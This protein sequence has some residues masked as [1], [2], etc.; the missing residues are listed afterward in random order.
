M[1]YG[2]IKEVL[3]KKKVR[4]S[5]GVHQVLSKLGQTDPKVRSFLKKNWDD[6]KNFL[7]DPSQDGTDPAINEGYI[8]K[9]GDSPFRVFRNRAFSVCPK[10]EGRLFP[11]F[12]FC[13]YCGFEVRK[14]DREPQRLDRDYRPRIG[15]QV[16]IRR[17][18]VNRRDTLGPHYFDTLGSKVIVEDEEV[19][20]TEQD[21][22]DA[23]KEIGKY[24]P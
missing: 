17:D 16:N 5:D 7:L 22:K 15:R 23:E 20:V 12:D 24:I 1:I 2:E 18:G 6:E 14:I 19:K 9:I 3:K 10:C 11:D 21:I 13:P 8:L 4:L